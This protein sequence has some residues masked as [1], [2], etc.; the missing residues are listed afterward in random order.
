MSNHTFQNSEIPGFHISKYKEQHGFQKYKIP[1]VQIK[2]KKK[3]I[4]DS[5]TLKFQG[6]NFQKLKATK[7]KIQK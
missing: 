5:Q 3:R 7:T 4:N 1:I 6:S 2:L